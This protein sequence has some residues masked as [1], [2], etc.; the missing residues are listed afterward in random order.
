MPPNVTV[1]LPAM[2]A[3]LRNGA[4]HLLESTLV[5]LGLFYLLLT[6]VGPGRWV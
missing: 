3:M 5:P 2:G 4:K 1:H 6:L